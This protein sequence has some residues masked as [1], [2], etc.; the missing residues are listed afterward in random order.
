MMKFVAWYDEDN[1]SCIGVTVSSK[2]TAVLDLTRL[3]QNIAVHDLPYST[4][5][6]DTRVAPLVIQNVDICSNGRVIENKQLIVVHIEGCI[7]SEL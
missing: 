3:M 6:S 7:A 2:Y 1:K 5:H 4:Y